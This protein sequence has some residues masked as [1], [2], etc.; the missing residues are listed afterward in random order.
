M[1]IPAVLGAWAGVVLFDILQPSSLARAYSLEL[2][3]RWPL[4]FSR[5]SYS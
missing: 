4:W 1:S 2:L 3:M 5:R